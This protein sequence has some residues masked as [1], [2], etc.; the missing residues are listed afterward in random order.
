MAKAGRR[1]RTTRELYI[2]LLQN[3]LRYAYPP[4]NRTSEL[5]LL[6]STAVMSLVSVK[7]GM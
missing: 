4:K 7:Y 3:H 2:D 5:N 6:G 1:E